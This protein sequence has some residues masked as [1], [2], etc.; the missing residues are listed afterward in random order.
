MTYY[1]VNHSN[2]GY[3]KGWKNK[4]EDNYT[5]DY[6]Y[7]KKYLS[8][9]DA[10]KRVGILIK[11]NVITYESFL[12]WNPSDKSA[13]RSVI[14]DNIM[15]DDRSGD[16]YVSTKGDIEKIVDGV[17][18]GSCG[19]EVFEYVMSQ[20]SKNQ[21]SYNK[22]KDKISKISATTSYISDG[23]FWDN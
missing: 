7:A 5:T 16:I 6:H 23:D 22:H 15:G 18:M 2:K 14:I 1:I 3:Y 9:K 19:E 11:N 8:I 10:I 21:I 17:N 4:L 12:E 20:I 13:K